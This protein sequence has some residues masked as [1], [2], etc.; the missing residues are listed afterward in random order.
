MTNSIYKCDKCEKSY[1]NARSLASHKKWHNKFFAEAARKG[2]SKGGVAS[3]EKNIKQQ[4]ID[5]YMK[6]PKKCSECGKVIPYSSRRNKFCNSSC[7]ASYTNKN[8]SFKRRG[9]MP[10]EPK[11]KIPFSKV[12]P[13]I[14]E[15]TGKIWWYNGRHRKLSPYRK[16]SKEQY[17]DKCA[18]KFKFNVYH[19]PDIFDL[20]LI[21]QHGWYSCPGR[22]RGSGI[23]N[24]KGV[25]RD[26][27]VSRKE[28][29]ENSYD[30]YYI[31]HIMN[32]DLM[33]HS[34]NKHK[35][36]R[37]S[38]TYEELVRLVTEYDNR[39]REDEVKK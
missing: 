14:C 4:N 39:R 12:E 15:Y 16:S 32:C 24:T 5:E 30:P 26:H 35:E 19:Y 33:L 25:S 11:E 13:R 17:Y 37:S 21:E 31:S 6:S 10:K 20:S 7:S 18:F 9:P 2:A 28:A 1:N 38:I 36:Y 23:N 27:K 34:E 29:F 22:K 8:I 3:R